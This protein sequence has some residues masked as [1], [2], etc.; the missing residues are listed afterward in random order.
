MDNYY[1]VQFPVSKYLNDLMNGKAVATTAT[2]DDTIHNY[3][4]YSS[5]TNSIIN[6]V[7][8]L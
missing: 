6:K 1:I 3:V 4:R 7:S 2:M 8:V 5:F